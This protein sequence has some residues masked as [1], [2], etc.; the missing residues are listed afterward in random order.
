MTMGD[1]GRENQRIACE[2]E[3]RSGRGPREE[4]VGQCLSVNPKMCVAGRETGGKVTE[5]VDFV[6]SISFRGN[7]G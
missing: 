1:E 7:P 5:S 2:S 6:R 3:E 4:T